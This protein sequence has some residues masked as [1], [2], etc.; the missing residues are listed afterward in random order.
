MVSA[1]VVYVVSERVSVLQ[2]LDAATGQLIWESPPDGL[3]RFV[4]SGAVYIESKDDV[5]ALDGATGDHLWRIEEPHWP[6]TQTEGIIITQSRGV[7]GL[8]AE[9]G[10]QV[11]SFQR[12]GHLANIRSVRDG[13]VVAVLR[14]SPTR[15]RD[16]PMPEM[17]FD[18]ELCALHAKKGWRLWCKK[19]DTIPFYVGHTGSVVYVPYG[20]RLDAF[21][22]KT[23]DEL[24]IHYV[25]A[26]R[27]MP[28]FADGILYF[29]ALDALDPETGVVLWRYRPE[30]PIAHDGNLLASL[31]GADGVVLVQTEG[32]LI[33]LASAKGVLSSKN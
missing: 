6:K 24:W 27:S 21:D 11:W 29:G 17:R 23:G 18:G 3:V 7:V 8:D 22:A 32:G 1:G 25:A 10:E 16:S 26:D 13:V 28:K 12:H 4:S 15:S 20:N 30:G 2:A 31:T 9:T 14:R 33:A 19:Y 5:V